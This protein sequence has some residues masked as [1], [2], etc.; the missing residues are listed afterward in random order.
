VAHTRRIRITIRRH[1]FPP[2]RELCRIVFR[3]TG[4]R[5]RKLAYTGNLVWKVVQT[6]ARNPRQTKGS[7]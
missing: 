3:I 4:H 7:P 5:P 2:P 6:A 1:I